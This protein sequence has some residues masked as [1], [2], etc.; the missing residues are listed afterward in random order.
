MLNLLTK[1]V[2]KS[3]LI[4]WTVLKKGSK[5]SELEKRVKKPSYALC[6]HET[7]LS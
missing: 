4:K 7:E 1:F 6:R 2:W 3:F 5:I